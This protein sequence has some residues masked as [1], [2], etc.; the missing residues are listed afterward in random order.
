[1]SKRLQV[2]LDEAEYREI[3][4]LARSQHAT[5]AAWV[6]D[7]LRAARRQQP[8]REA[9]GKLAALRAAAGH[10]YPTADIGEMLADIERGRGGELP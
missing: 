9:E 3:K 7:A 8:S 10:A 5:V 6:R 2:L 4:R 1:M